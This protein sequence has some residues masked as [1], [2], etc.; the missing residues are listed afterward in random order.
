VGSASLASTHHSHQPPEDQRDN[1]APSLVDRELTKNPAIA[2]LP[3]QHPW[4]LVSPESRVARS[5]E[6]PKPERDHNPEHNNKPAS[7]DQKQA[8]KV[9]NAMNHHI[10]GKPTRP[11]AVSQHPFHGQKVDGP[12][13]R[14]RPTRATCSRSEELS[15]FKDRASTARVCQTTTAPKPITK[16][17]GRGQ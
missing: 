17:N 2:P 6:R 15:S 10:T 4:R 14:E 5:A 1:T 9:S 8:A 12:A 3:Q 16:S 13:D 7:P 11:N